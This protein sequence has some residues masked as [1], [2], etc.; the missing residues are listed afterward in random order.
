M[1]Q[2]LLVQHDI[3][4]TSEEEAEEEEEEVENPF[5]S[6]ATRP[7]KHGRHRSHHHNRKNSHGTT[8]KPF[9]NRNQILGVHKRIRKTKLQSID[10]EDFQTPPPLPSTSP[11]TPPPL[12]STPKPTKVTKPRKHRYLDI[13][14]NEPQIVLLPT[15]PPL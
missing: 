11:P 15:P 13:Q 10:S 8:R 9:L 1:T 6:I 5:E 7:P 4:E 3:A 12:P 2:H 14:L